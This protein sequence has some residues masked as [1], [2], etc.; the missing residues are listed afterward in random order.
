MPPR[1][2]NTTPAGIVVASPKARLLTV[3]FLP[4]CEC[5]SGF[6]PPTHTRSIHVNG[7]ERE[8]SSKPTSWRYSSSPRPGCRVIRSR[9]LGRI[10]VDFAV[11]PQRR[12]SHGAPVAIDAAHT[13]H[14]VML[15]LTLLALSRRPQP[16]VMR[17]VVPA[18]VLHHRPHR[19]LPSQF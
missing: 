18:P 12:P 19:L 5:L 11:L 16:R 6:Q 1:V 9:L 15:V 2:E 4:S 3:V 14:G 8:R 7:L 13:D 10:A 17:R